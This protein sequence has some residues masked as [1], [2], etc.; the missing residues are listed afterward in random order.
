ML[1]NCGKDIL[2][3]Y[4]VTYMFVEVKKIMLYNQGVGI[5]QCGV[6]MLFATMYRYC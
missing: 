1:L 2:H 4:I 6:L 3:V 5:T